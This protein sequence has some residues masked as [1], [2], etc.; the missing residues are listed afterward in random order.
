[1]ACSCPL[2]ARTPTCSTRYL[3]EIDVQN[4]GTVKLTG[5]E[6]TA[7]IGYDSDAKVYTFTDEN[8]NAL[9]MKS[10][11]RL[12]QNPELDGLVAG[13]DYA[14]TIADQKVNGAQA[15]FNVDDSGSLVLNSDI[16]YVLDDPDGNGSIGTDSTYGTVTG[17]QRL[18]C[19]H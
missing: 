6:A 7:V 15:W 8:G 14:N 4:D 17:S 5:Q 12:E 19:L 9:P 2:T 13:F 10:T 3:R 18:Y 1:M 11:I 16:D